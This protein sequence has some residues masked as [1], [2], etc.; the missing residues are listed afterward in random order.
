MKKTPIIYLL[1]VSILIITG[2]GGKKTETRPG[3]LKPGTA[4][5]YLNEGLFYLNGG[6]IAMAEKKLKM[7]LKKNPNLVGAIN[8]MGIVYLNKREF[9]NAVRNFRRVVQ[10]NPQAIDAYNYLGVIFSETG[11]YELAKENF[12]IAANAEKYRN[13]ENSYANLAM[14]E[15]KHKKLDSA[16]RYVEK[17][18]QFNK[19]FAPLHNVKGIIFENQ[20]DYKKALYYYEKALS[21]LTEDDISYLLNIGRVYAKMGQKNKSLDTLEKALSKAYS[22]QLKEQVRAMIKEL[23]TKKDTK[24]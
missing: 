1:I 3:Q 8:G 13:P 19:N 2:C 23:D 21:L 7:A 11:K 12:L 9:D 16:L 6:N 17:G 20:K 10:L 4:E 14:L 15:V 5:F 18:V 22:P 24:Q